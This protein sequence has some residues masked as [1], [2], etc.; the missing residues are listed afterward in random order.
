MHIDGWT[1]V[2]QTV[3]FLVLVLLLRR[4]LYRPVLAAIDRRKAEAT[5]DLDA[6]ALRL[7]DAEAASRAAEARRAELDVRA[8]T[9]LAEARTRVEAETRTQRDRARAEADAVLAEARGRLAQERAEAEV[10]LRAHAAALAVDIAS[11]LVADLGGDAPVDP[12]LERA[13]AGLAALDPA[14]RRDLTEQA[15]RGG[16][17]VVSMRPLDAAEQLRAET[18]VTGALGAPVAVAFIHDPALLAGVEL[19]FSHTV[20]HESWRDRLV[21]TERDLVDH[22]DAEPVA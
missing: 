19:R 2:F 11:A 15:A 17:T 9:L 21:R 12:F 6:A 3:N 20:V 18:L 13:A 7:A 1:L 14:D 22:V 8:E 4:F 10:A 5:R 16:V